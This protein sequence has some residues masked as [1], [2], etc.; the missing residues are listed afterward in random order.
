MQYRK[1]QAMKSN[2]S[3]T[4]MQTA[5]A[6]RVIFC[7]NR[8]LRYE[9]VHLYNHRIVCGLGLAAP[10]LIAYTLQLPV[11][12]HIFRMIRA[13]DVL[14]VSQVDLLTPCPLLLCLAVTIGG[15]ISTPIS[16]VLAPANT[17]AFRII[18]IKL[19]VQ[20]VVR[21]GFPATIFTANRSWHSISP[22]FG[23]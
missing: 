3:L 12:L 1:P 13:I 6:A 22:E 4:I 5:A 23:E 21:L 8:Q 16:L 19:F 10:F 18:T 2:E 17:L 15:I 20:S 14:V 9:R 11:P 7:K